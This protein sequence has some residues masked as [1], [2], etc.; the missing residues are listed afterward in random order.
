MHERDRLLARLTAPL[1][2]TM[3]ANASTSTGVDVV[4]CASL[5]LIV[6]LDAHREVDGLA[7][8]LLVCA[9][10]IHRGMGHISVCWPRDWLRPSVRLI[11]ATIRDS[12]SCCA[13][14]DAN[15]FA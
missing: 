3:K 2:M 11:E 4:P 15:A 10:V 8:R 1:I 14:S 6:S 12:Q 5:A 9:K 13:H 7:N